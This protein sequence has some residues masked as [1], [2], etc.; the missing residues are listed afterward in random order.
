MANESSAYGETGFEVQLYVY[1]LSKGLAKELSPALLGKELPGV[2][3]T[4]IVVRGMEYFFGS[5]GIDSCP[6]GQT[7][8][9]EPDKV[10]SLGRTELPHDVFL[11]Y[12]WQLGEYSYKASTYDLFRHNC[13]NFSQHVA[14]FLTGNSIPREIVE[15]PDDFLSTPL[16]RTLVPLFERLAIAVDMAL[17]QDSLSGQNSKS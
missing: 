11:D 16:G 13:N 12:M 9:Q 8:L 7:A 17:G 10:V 6:A 5:T 1:D 4:S 3:H 2:W 15:L 14:V